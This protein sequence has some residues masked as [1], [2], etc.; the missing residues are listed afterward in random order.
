[1][2]E[3]TQKATPEQ[4][5]AIVVGN[6]KPGRN[7]LGVGTRVL[8]LWLVGIVVLAGVALGAYVL[9]MHFISPKNPAAKTGLSPQQI[10]N[11]AVNKTTLNPN[12][13]EA[14]NVL[15]GQLKTAKTA[16]T[17]AN[18]YVQLA[19]VANSQN[20]NQQY[21]DYLLAA[22]KTDPSMEPTLAM[23]IGDA[24]KAA[25]NKAQAITYYQQAIAYYTQLAKMPAGESSGNSYF[26]AQA[27]SNIQELQK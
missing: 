14:N 23:N 6:Q 24:Y 21:L 9:Y 1:M 13:S 17:K 4:K 3:H 12:Y 7:K 8:L 2:S 22:A 5:S 20:Q 25:G 10:V 18:I 19:S 15:L 16:Q 27:Q 26:I 11:Q